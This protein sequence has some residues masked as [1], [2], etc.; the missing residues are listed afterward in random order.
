MGGILKGTDTIFFVKYDNI[1]SESRKYITYG[2]ILVD[3]HTQNDEPNRTRLT[4][5]GYLIDESG[6]V[7]TP[8]SDTT[9]AKIVCT[10]VLSSH[11]SPSICLLT[12]KQLPGCTIIRNEYL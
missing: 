8:T 3:Y 7:S 11:L 2:H 6:D 10:I 9:T 5:G 12:P 4:V 1:P